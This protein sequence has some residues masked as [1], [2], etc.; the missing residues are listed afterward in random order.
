MQKTATLSLLLALS[1][2]GSNPVIEYREVKVPV[3][4][5]CVDGWPEVPAWE[6]ATLEDQSTL[7]VVADA[8]MIELE[9]RKNYEKRL[10]DIIKGCITDE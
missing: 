5:P 10:A 9:Q 3:H 7:P 8:Y 1:G 4:T 2:C 6:T